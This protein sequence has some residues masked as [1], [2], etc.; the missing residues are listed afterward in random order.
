M[1]H[2][3]IAIDLPNDANECR[4]FGESSHGFTLLLA[5]TPPPPHNQ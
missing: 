3:Q 4:Q 5:E 2:Y 1:E